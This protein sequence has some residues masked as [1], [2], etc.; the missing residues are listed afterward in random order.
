MQRACQ[1]AMRVFSEAPGL[2]VHF[3]LARLRNERVRGRRK[4][5]NRVPHAFRIR[6]LAN[7]RD[8]LRYGVFVGRVVAHSFSSSDDALVA[9]GGLPVNR[10]FNHHVERRNVHQKMPFHLQ[11]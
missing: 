8:D 3:K 7:L 9:P 4:L 11:R 10:N 6:F 1:L 2:P 5:C